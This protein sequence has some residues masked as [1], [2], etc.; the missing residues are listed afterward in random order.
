MSRIAIA[1]ATLLLAVSAFAQD[2]RFSIERIEVRNA[3]RMRPGV[4]ADETLLRV[5][6]EYSEEDVRRAV[7]RLE[8]LPFLFSADY[9]LEPGSDAAH[10]VVVITV[11]E[12]RPVSFLGDGRFVWLD[13]T[14]S[15]LESD[16]DYDDLTTQ[17]K[18]A[19]VGVRWLVGG[20]G[21]A[22][23]G[24]TVLRSRQNFRKNYAAWEVGYTHF[25]ILGSR[26][27]A[28]AVVR[29]PVDSV[30]EGTFTPAF[31]VGLPLTA[32]QTIA[33]ELEDTVFVRGTFTI[34]GTS[35]R[36]L[37]AERTASLSWTY[38]TTNGPF[39]RTRGT[40][41]RIKPF[42]WMRDD[43]DFRS[44][45]R[46]PSFVATATHMH[47]DGVEAAALRYWELSNAQSV[48]AGV[49]GGWTRV[50][51][52]SVDRQPSYEVLKGGYSRPIWPRDARL[53]LEARLAIYQ[54]DVEFLLNDHDKSAEVLASWAWKSVWG[55]VR[56]GAGYARG[57]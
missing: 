3:Q 47:A 56:V 33:A 55:T 15:L 8:R 46:P 9:T 26:V 35:F 50:D 20:H 39:L 53:E 49:L 30:D 36:Q 12:L 51:G 23:A 2:T 43:A 5:G 17:W 34:Q 14:A 22:H 18:N 57:F 44:V 13:E 29:T 40:F 21:F 54:P 38:D 31:I 42:R 45:P 48:F 6:R 19:A 24:M 27:F 7:E 28:T 16:Y 52:P 11:T 10:R 25:D 32:S 37:H 41:L 4:I 1:F